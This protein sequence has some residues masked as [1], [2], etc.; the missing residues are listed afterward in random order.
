MA[1]DAYA[2]ITDYDERDHYGYGDDA[3]ADDPEYPEIVPGGASRYGT[4]GIAAAD[5]G[6]ADEVSEEAI[7]EALA[8]DDRLAA[9]RLAPPPLAG[10]ARH[11]RPLTRP[12]Q[13]WGACFWCKPDVYLK[14]AES[15]VLENPAPKIGT[16][17]TGKPRKPSADQRRAL[18]RHQ[19]AVAYQ[20]R[21]KADV[22]RIK[23][24]DTKIDEQAQLL[25]EALAPPGGTPCVDCGSTLPPGRRWR[26]EAC[27]AGAL[28]AIPMELRIRA[29]GPSGSPT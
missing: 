12:E 25:G 27:T 14:Y 24:I 11:N 13:L 2:N 26:C 10:C 15:R 16:T 4:R 6:V 21:A 20:T 9:Q 8:D 23:E 28:A 7:A 3:P 1:G 17:P 5:A 29:F 18:A 19:E 22:E